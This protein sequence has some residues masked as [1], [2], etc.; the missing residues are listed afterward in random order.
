MNLQTK[1]P[2][3]FEKIIP[4]YFYSIKEYI[5]YFWNIILLVINSK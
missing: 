5:S 4:H 1:Y 2:T 3:I